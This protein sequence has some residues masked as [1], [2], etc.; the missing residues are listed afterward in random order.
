VQRRPPPRF[1]HRRVQHLTSRTRTWGSNGSSDGARAK[2][3]DVEPRPRAPMRKKQGRNLTHDAVRNFGSPRTI[4][5]RSRAASPRQLHGREG[6]P[7]TLQDGY[8]F[9]KDRFVTYITRTGASRGLDERKR[10]A[11][12]RPSCVGPSA[13]TLLPATSRRASRGTSE[14]ARSRAA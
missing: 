2:A 14:A 9:Q 12:R 5:R 11:F 1:A 8:H 4:G 13:Y 3:R 10:P 6:Q 7:P